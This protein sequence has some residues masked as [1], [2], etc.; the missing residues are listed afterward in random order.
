MAVQVCRACLH[1]CLFRGE[2]QRE[3]LF[4]RR[5][6]L[7]SFHA[8]LR[9]SPPACHAYRCLP[10]LSSGSML[11]EYVFCQ[12]P[13]R[14]FFTRK[15]AGSRAALPF[16]PPCLPGSA[17]RTVRHV[18][19]RL[20]Q[21]Q[22]MPCALPAASCLLFLPASEACLCHVFQ[23]IAGSRLSMLVRRREGT[24]HAQLPCPGPF[25]PP[26]QAWHAR[27]TAPIMLAALACHCLAGRRRG[28]GKQGCPAKWGKGMPSRRH[29]S[30]VLLTV[31]VGVSSCWQGKG[32][33]GRHGEGLGKE[34]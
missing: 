13:H 26:A 4:Q 22:A 14:V 2:V 32:W 30:H 11:V 18:T 1:R 34:G 20:P 6:S 5:L 16:R 8:F 3:C 21:P 31:W 9:F 27:L 25:R 24:G 10:G 29:A 17:V 23:A 15:R 33:L 7:L 12:L 28:F 19:D